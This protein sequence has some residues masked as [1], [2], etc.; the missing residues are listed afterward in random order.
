LDRVLVDL[1]CGEVAA[2]LGHDGVGAVDAGQAFKEL[3][4]DS[5][6]GVELRNRLRGSTGLSLPASLVFDHPTPAALAAFLRA[7]LVPHVSLPAGEDESEAKIREVLASIP[8]SR[9]RQ[10][11]LLDMVLQLAQ[12]AGNASAPATQNA[13]SIDEMDG[14]SLLQLAAESSEN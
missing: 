12:P 9:F 5:L 8:I 10:A 11:G 4:F 6:T 14:E 3:G 7:E 13:M 1:V 2:V